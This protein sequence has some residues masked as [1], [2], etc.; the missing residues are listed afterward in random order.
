VCSANYVFRHYKKKESCL[1]N[2]GLHHPFCEAFYWSRPLLENIRS[3][4]WYRGEFT[5]YVKILPSLMPVF[6]QN[7]KGDKTERLSLPGKYSP[8]LDCEAINE[9]L[10][11]RLP[12]PLTLIYCCNFQLSLRNDVNTLWMIRIGQCSE[13][14][15]FPT[16][17][18]SLPVG[19]RG[20]RMG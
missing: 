17:E 18:Q 11:R 20:L 13:P 16:S 19:G 1:Q 3:G 12:Q 8:P 4:H 2:P 7:W 15:N 14:E 10:G 6:S 9:V 5:S